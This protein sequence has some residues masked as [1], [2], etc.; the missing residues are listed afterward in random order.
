MSTVLCVHVLLTVSTLPASVQL[1]SQR[2]S[3][4][5]TKWPL[6]DDPRG[7]VDV[8]SESCCKLFREHS[9]LIQLSTM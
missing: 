9:N 1:C 6:D 5:W 2:G 7:R 4:Y 8:S 3:F